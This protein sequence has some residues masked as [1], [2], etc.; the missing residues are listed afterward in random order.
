MS[1]GVPLAALFTPGT[2]Y[3]QGEA[4]GR[5]FPET[6]MQPST[7]TVAADTPVQG[8]PHMRAR[9]PVRTR[10]TYTRTPVRT[11]AHAR[12]RRSARRSAAARA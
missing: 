7:A 3:P 9:T 11:R 2:G 8:Y 4:A 1:C 6:Q 10:T 12:M 5:L